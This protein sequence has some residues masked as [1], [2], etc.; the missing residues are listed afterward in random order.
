MTDTTTSNSASASGLYKWGKK[1]DEGNV[2]EAAQ[3][4]MDL[5]FHDFDEVVVSFSGGKDSTCILNVALDAAERHDALPLRVVFFD[6]EAIAPDTEEY[7]RRVAADPR[8]QLEWYCVPVRHRNGASMDDGFWFP[9]APEKSDLWCRDLPPE[10]I[11]DIEGVDWSIDNRPS[12]P[13]LMPFVTDPHSG[14]TAMLLGIRADESLVRR[15]AVSVASRR[16]AWQIKPDNKT[17]WMTKCYPVYDWTTKDVW[18][19]PRLLGWDYNTFYDVLEMA[20]VGHAQQRCAPPFGDEPLRDLH[21]WQETYPELWDKMC[22]RVPGAQAAARYANTSLYGTFSPFICPV[23]KTPQQIIRE[24]IDDH[25]D[26]SM[27]KAYQ[28][29]QEQVN[30]KSESSLLIK[31]QKY[32]AFVIFEKDKLEFKPNKSGR[33]RS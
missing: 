29:F 27:Q 19:A 11:T 13:D 25:E 30:T 20:G 3:S 33:R 24:R 15:K 21:V 23:G 18:T 28:D 31:F 12:I 22:V 9:W 26:E 10:A 8:V 7:V 14:R 4:R 16:Y 6:E 32:K 1:S 2:Y 5:I 17:P